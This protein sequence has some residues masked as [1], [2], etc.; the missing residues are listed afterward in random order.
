MF[1]LGECTC[2]MEHDEMK[3]V[4]EAEGCEALRGGGMTVAMELGLVAHGE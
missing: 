4:T 1:G 3:V 2:K